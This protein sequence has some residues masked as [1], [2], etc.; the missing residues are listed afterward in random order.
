MQLLC[1]QSLLMSTQSAQRLAR[2]PFRARGMRFLHI[3]APAG[4][5]AS[6]IGDVST[7]YPSRRWQNN[8]GPEQTDL[9]SNKNLFAAAPPGLRRFV[10]ATS[11]GVDRYDRFPYLILNLF[12]ASTSWAL[13]IT[14]PSVNACVRTTEVVHSAGVL[15]Y[16][17][18]AEQILEQSGLPYTIIR[19]GRLTDGEHGLRHRRGPL[20]KSLPHWMNQLL[21]TFAQVLTRAST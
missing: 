13:R 6:S 18:Q 1:Q 19:P 9:I 4:R 10:M 7:S 17:K 2:P 11:T 14:W 3:T 21:T 15:K 8:N 16:K 12:G 20:N 5:T